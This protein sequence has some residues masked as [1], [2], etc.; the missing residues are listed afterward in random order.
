MASTT[1]VIHLPRMREIRSAFKSALIRSKG[2][3]LQVN[4][5]VFRIEN[6]EMMTGK[7]NDVPR[8][9][10]GS[11]KTAVEYQ[12]AEPSLEAMLEFNGINTMELEAYARIRKM[13]MMTLHNVPFGWIQELQRRGGNSR[14]LML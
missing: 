11:A 13:P 14:R 1:F 12:V 10:S 4:T 3:K 5:V 2:E 8:T 9:M 7:S 6:N